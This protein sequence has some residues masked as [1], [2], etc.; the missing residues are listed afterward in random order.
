LSP[1]SIAFPNC[2]SNFNFSANIERNI[3]V[4]DEVAWNHHNHCQQP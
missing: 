3:W 1:A 4:T 2:N